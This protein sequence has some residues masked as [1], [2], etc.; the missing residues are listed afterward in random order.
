MSLEQ[1]SL[2]GKSFWMSDEEDVRRTNVIG[3]NV[4]AVKSFWMFFKVDVFER[5]LLEQMS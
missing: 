2:V 4:I 5:M 3:T 1:M